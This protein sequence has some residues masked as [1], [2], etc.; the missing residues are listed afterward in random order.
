MIKED[1]EEVKE[2]VLWD[3]TMEESFIT[4]V[5]LQNIFKEMRQFTTGVYED[6][7]GRTVKE[8]G[9]IP[10]Q[11]NVNKK[12]K[13]ENQDEINVFAVAAVL[14]TEYASFAL[15]IDIG[16]R[17]MIVF[18]PSKWIMKCPTKHLMLAYKLFTQQT[19]CNFLGGECM[20]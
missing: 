12:T 8:E 19:Y 18:D 5:D 15:F 7:N 20:K 16:G 17:R 3:S 4:E 13:G 11:E 1:L 10:L 6:D 2:E 9:S 14:C